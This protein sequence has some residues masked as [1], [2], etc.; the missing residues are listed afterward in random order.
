MNRIRIL[1]KRTPTDAGA[2]MTLLLKQDGFCRAA[3][4]PETQ[5]C[6]MSLFPPDSDRQNTRALAGFV[7]SPRA[8]C[9]FL[10]PCSNVLS[11]VASH[12]ASEKWRQIRQLR[13]VER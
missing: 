13:L 11:V 12:L 7:C 8:T 2:C 4:L 5:M 6:T 1:R 9:G 10:P 3:V